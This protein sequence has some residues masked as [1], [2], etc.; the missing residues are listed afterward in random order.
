M[1]R[2]SNSHV[3]MEVSQQDALAGV[4]S[5]ASYVRSPSCALPCNPASRLPSVQAVFSVAHVAKVAQA[6]VCRI[7]VNVVDYVRLFAVS[8]KPS[9]SVGVVQT[10]LVVESDV[11][12]AVN[13]PNRAK[14]GAPFEFYAVDD[15]AFRVVREVFFNRFWNNLESH[16]K[17]TF[18]VVRGL[19]I[20]VLST[21]ILPY[22]P[23]RWGDTAITR[24]G[25]SSQHYLITL[26]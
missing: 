1:I 19:R 22:F 7:A 2:C 26:P 10:P 5:P 9:N 12:G 20:A 11:A 18:D 13:K 16:I 6:V 15:S 4:D 24:P 17:L 3:P 8:K 25:R 23:N 14:F 21:P